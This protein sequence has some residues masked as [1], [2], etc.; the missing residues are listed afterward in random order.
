MLVWSSSDLIICNIGGWGCIRKSD[1]VDMI[2]T[3]MDGVKATI[4]ME[5]AFLTLEHNRLEGQKYRQYPPCSIILPG[6]FNCPLMEQK[7]N[8]DLPETIN[9]RKSTSR[10]SSPPWLSTDV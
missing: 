2:G 8:F 3:T 5:T 1:L 10:S 7:R 6:L 4:V 9:L